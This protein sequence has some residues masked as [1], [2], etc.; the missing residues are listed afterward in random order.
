MKK[1]SVR[2]LIGILAILLVS[3][4]CSKKEDPAPATPGCSF[5]FKGTSYSM[6]ISICD[7]DATNGGKINT[8]A[9]LTATYGLT[10]TDG[11]AANG[12][13]FTDVANLTSYTSFE[14]GGSHTITISGT[15]W[16][17]SGTLKN[18]DDNSNS[19]TISGTCTCTVTNP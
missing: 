13:V 15:T 10:L 5:T 18:V 9:N 8:A 14:A 7:D 3:V 19:G 12:I 17:F 11:G 2:Y 1:R 16:T 6:Q 4:Q